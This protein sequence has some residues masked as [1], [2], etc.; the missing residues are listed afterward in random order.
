MGGNAPDRRT[1]TRRADTTGTG[2]PAGMVPITDDPRNVGGYRDPATGFEYNSRGEL[3]WV[4]SGGGALDRIYKRNN[5]AVQ[6][7]ADT[8]KA[9]AMPRNLKPSGGAPVGGSA[10]S[11]GD[12]G[13]VG[14]MQS[15]SGAAPTSHGLVSGPQSPP[16]PPMVGSTQQSPSLPF[17]ISASPSVDAG[18]V[19]GVARPTTA[20]QAAISPEEWAMITQA[21]VMPQELVQIPR[22]QGQTLP[23]RP[24]PVP[25]YAPAA[26]ELPWY[27]QLLNAIF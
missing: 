24:L 14:D 12:T 19:T 18:V 16:P 13:V 1:K 26:E 17:T 25:Q 6:Q 2:I 22:P 4:Y 9:Q 5:P 27:Q 20:P 11:P 3:A 15:R 23:P 7:Q 10:G 8:A 21:P